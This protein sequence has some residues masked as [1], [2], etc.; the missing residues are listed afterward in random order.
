MQRK[1]L[2]SAYAAL[3]QVRWV[4]ADCSALSPTPAPAPFAQYVEI[5]PHDMDGSLNSAKHGWGKACS[6]FAL[7]EAANKELQD[8]PDEPDQGEALSFDPN[9]Q[10]AGLPTAE[11]MS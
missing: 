10:P 2:L 6:P 7:R 5:D 11:N 1:A 4:A 8:E 9:P 3:L